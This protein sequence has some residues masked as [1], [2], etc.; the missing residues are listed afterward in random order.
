MNKLEQVNAKVDL[1]RKEAVVKLGRE[2]S[3]QELKAVVEKA[4]YVVISIS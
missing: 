1:S 3:D 2:I 4:G